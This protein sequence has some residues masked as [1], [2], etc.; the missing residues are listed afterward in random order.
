MLKIIMLKMY[1]YIW[2]KSKIQLN[3]SGLEPITIYFYYNLCTCQCVVNSSGVR[4]FLS[5]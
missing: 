5:E 2:E 3:F 1:W 4:Q